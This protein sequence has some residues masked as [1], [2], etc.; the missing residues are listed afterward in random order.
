MISKKKRSLSQKSG[1]SP[2]I[3]LAKAPSLLIFRGTVLS[4]GGTIF[5]WGGTSSHLEGHGPEMP[6]RGAGPGLEQESLFMLVN[7]ISYTSMVQI[8]KNWAKPD[9]K[10][11][12]RKSLNFKTKIENF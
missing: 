3:P 2:K 4:W 10:I 6:P 5:V 11:F 9:L 1:V 7:T 12:L 8:F